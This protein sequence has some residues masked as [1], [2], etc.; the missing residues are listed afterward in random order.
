MNKLFGTYK[1]LNQDTMCQLYQSYCCS[2]YGSQLWDFKSAGFKKCCVQWNKAVRR[3]FN[4]H[5]RTHTWLLGPLLD[6]PHISCQLYVKTL[7]FLY[8]M[9]QHENNIVA[10]VGNMALS[11]AT[12]PIGRNMSYLRH[13]FDVNFTESLSQCVNRV[14][15]GTQ[16]CSE[17]ELVVNH[18]QSIFSCLQGVSYIDGFDNEMLHI[19]LTNLCVE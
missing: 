9:L 17:H 18:V 3:L 12:S 10:S 1:G 11:C 5:Y 7:K 8:Y 16:I 4:L 19:L 6:K 2:F 15:R 13:V 14:Y